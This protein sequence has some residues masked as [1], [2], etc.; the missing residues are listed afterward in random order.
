MSTASAW[1]SILSP[2]VRSWRQVRAEGVRGPGS[3]VRYEEWRQGSMYIG[4]G[5]DTL[6][7]RSKQ[8]GLVADGQSWPSR[9]MVSRPRG[10]PR[11]GPGGSWGTGLSP[12]QPGSGGA[13]VG[14]A[15]LGR[16]SRARPARSCG[17]EPGSGRQSSAGGVERSRSRGESGWAECRRRGPPGRSR[18]TARSGPLGAAQPKLLRSGAEVEEPKWAWEVQFGLGRWSSAGSRAVR[19]KSARG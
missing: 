13:E 19:W 10:R 17:V 9:S 6:A 11:S 2:P 18:G 3:C 7:V 8:L 14:G 1:S 5:V 12:A 16:R 4:F 15:G